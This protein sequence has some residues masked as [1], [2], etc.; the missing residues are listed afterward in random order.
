MTKNT[1]QSPP[2]GVKPRRQ[3]CR[4]NHLLPDGTPI[5]ALFEVPLRHAPGV[6]AGRT[7]LMFV[8]TAPPGHVALL[9]RLF[10][11]HVEQ[12][13][14]ERHFGSGCHLAQFE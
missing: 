9:H 8:G 7:F 1:Q 13:L 6:L 5:P 10:K 4:A 11:R 14:Q 2:G 3:L 12:A